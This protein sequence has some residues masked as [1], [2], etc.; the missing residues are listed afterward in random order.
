M[1]SFAVAGASRGIGYEFIVQLSSDPSNTVFALVRNPDGAAKLQALASKRNN[2]HVIK[3][4]VSDP[5][6]LIEAAEAVSAV[7]SGTLDVLI[8]N[9]VAQDPSTANLTASQLPLDSEKMY[10]AF[11]G[12]L[13][14]GVFGATWSANAFLPLIEKGAQ[15][16]IIFISSAMG[17]L[18][19]VR[20]A[21]V[22]NAVIYGI[23]KAAMNMLAVKFAAE[24][25]PKGINV[26]AL[27]PGWVNTQESSQGSFTHLDGDSN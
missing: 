19:F 10:A 2:I 21:A 6:S 24:L 27:S 13:E 12:S 5:R 17:D 8:H 18:D 14:T 23:E 25:A 20:Q 1:S 11:K 4:D 3:T 7:T 22:S 9:A 15:K 26:L 16:K